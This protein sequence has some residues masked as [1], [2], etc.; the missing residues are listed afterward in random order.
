MS[1]VRL[2]FVGAAAVIAAAALPGSAQAA[3]GYDRCVSG[4]VCFFTG[5]DGGGRMCAWDWHDKDWTREPITCSWS[6]DVNVQSVFNNGKRT[7]DGKFQDVAY[8]E[9]TNYTTRKGCT[10]LGKKGNLAGTY[11]LRSHQ[12]LEGSC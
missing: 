11:T 1:R 10:K 3:D 9:F 6:G 8:Y 7:P 12:W 4:D 5:K 2:A